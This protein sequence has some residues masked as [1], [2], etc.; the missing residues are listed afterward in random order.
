MIVPH[1]TVF[2]RIL[3]HLRFRLIE[4]QMIILVDYQGRKKKKSPHTRR[5]TKNRNFLESYLP[6]LDHILPIAP[7]PAFA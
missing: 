5:L 7:L 2:G 6:S 3:N 4:N 1:E